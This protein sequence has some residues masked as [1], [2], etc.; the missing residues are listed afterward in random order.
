M[1][2]VERD[3][4][5]TVFLRERGRRIEYIDAVLHMLNSNMNSIAENSIEKSIKYLNDIIKNDDLLRKLFMNLMSYSRTMA[6]L[7]VD[8]AKERM[9][10][11][12]L[13]GDDYLFLTEDE[14]FTILYNKYEERATEGNDLDLADMINLDTLQALFKC[15]KFSDS[16]KA[17]F[18]RLFVNKTFYDNNTFVQFSPEDIYDVVKLL[19]LRELLVDKINKEKSKEQKEAL[20]HDLIFLERNILGYTDNAYTGIFAGTKVSEIQDLLSKHIAE[21]NKIIEKYQSKLNPPTKQEKKPGLFKS[22]FSK[23]S[24][25][26]EQKSDQDNNTER[27]GEEIAYQVDNISQDLKKALEEYKASL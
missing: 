27:I 11:H 7:R 3:E 6:I 9:T 26:E 13:L 25:E 19:K 2:T 20:M 1:S 24:R 10:V 16:D 12:Y 18:E 4:S 15:I 21:C 22:L 17:N 8:Y 23:S 5:Y 14:L